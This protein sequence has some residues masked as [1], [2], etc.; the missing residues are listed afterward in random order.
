MSELINGFSEMLFSLSHTVR[1]L[2]K[3]KTSASLEQKN[4]NSQIKTIFIQNSL[5]TYNGDFYWKTKKDH[6]SPNQYL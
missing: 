2:E 6:C 4:K 1:R 3:S 5:L